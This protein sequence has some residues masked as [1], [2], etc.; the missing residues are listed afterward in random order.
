MRVLTSR[1]SGALAIDRLCVHGFFG[2]LILGLSVFIYFQLSSEVSSPCPSQ[3]MIALLDSF[4]GSIYFAKKGS[5]QAPKTSPK[6]RVR[7][8]N[9]G[10]QNAP[11]VLWKPGFFTKRTPEYSH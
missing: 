6:R 5:L 10:A 8:A 1:Y 9:P 11:S 2:T 7:F 4:A 3:R